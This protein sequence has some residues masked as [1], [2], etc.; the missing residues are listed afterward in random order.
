MH[1]NDLVYPQMEGA[2]Q[3]GEKPLWRRKEKPCTLVRYII[4]PPAYPRPSSSPAYLVKLN[5]MKHT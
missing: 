1:S 5:G 2:M 4:P 3:N